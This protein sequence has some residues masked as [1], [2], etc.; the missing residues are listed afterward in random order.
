MLLSPPPPPSSQIMLPWTGFEERH[1]FQFQIPK[2][3]R[4]DK[5][6]VCTYRGC[7]TEAGLNGLVHYFTNATCRGI[8]N[9]KDNVVLQILKVSVR[10]K[11]SPLVPYTSTNGAS[12][13]QGVQYE[14]FQFTKA[15]HCQHVRPLASLL[16][17]TGNF[18]S[19]MF[20]YVWNM[21][22]AACWLAILAV[23]FLSMMRKDWVL[24]SNDSLL[25]L[26]H[27]CYRS[28]LFQQ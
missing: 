27:Y 22:Y 8:L 4:P 1:S 2:H 18:N 16:L 5:G 6:Q 7:G 20:N 13:V 9:G 11:Y 17:S 23:S 19:T 26:S 3:A 24:H 21:P 25:L 28:L 10:L 14:T 12:W 15:W